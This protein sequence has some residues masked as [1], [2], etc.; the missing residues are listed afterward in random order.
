[1]KQLVHALAFESTQEA[2]AAPR[3]T[4]TPLSCSPNL[5]RGQYLDIRK[6]THELIVNENRPSF[7]SVLAAWCSSRF[8]CMLQT[9]QA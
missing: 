6:L 9:F 3:A 8:C 7:V 1:M 5:P 2:R 4:L